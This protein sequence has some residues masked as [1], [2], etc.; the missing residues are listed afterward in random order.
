[1]GAVAFFVLR[2]SEGGGGGIFGG[3]GGNDT[4]PTLELRITKTIAVSTTATPAKKLKAGASSIAKK[5]TD[6]M[7]RLYTAAFLDP[8]NWRDNSYDDVWAMFD[9]GARAAAQQEVEA[10]TLGS[11]AGDVYN[12]VAEPIGKIEVRVLMNEN[13][14]PATAVAIVDFTATATGKDG[15]KTLVVSTGQYFLKEVS[16]NWAIY[17]YSVR[18]EDHPIVPTPGPS[19]SPSTVSS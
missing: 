13:D 15:T 9:Q 2:G 10:V 17:S 4:I 8:G 12:K 14:Q 11:T 1:M 3:G 19:G 6:A 7:N 16:G 18:R 5:V